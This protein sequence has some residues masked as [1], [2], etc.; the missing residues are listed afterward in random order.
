MSRRRPVALPADGRIGVRTRARLSLELLA[1][2]GPLLRAV[3]RDDLPAM[4]RAARATRGARRSTR[5]EAAHPTAVWLGRVVRRFFD[6]LPMDARCL[7]R[8]LVL[9]RLLERR[10]IPA[11]LV[12]G[13]ASD[14]P[15]SAHAWVEHDAV[16]LLPTG[17]MARLAEF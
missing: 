5:P 11:R 17:R 13:V 2:Y 3:R 16:A 4:A 10:G 15:F 7:I 9:L 1:A 8:S 12:I 6:V 14:G